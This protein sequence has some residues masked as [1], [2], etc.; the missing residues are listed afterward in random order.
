MKKIFAILALF[1]A[2]SI[3][4]N[5][6]ENK[7]SSDVTVSANNDFE[8]LNSFLTVD[9]ALKP[10]LVQI[11]K[12]KHEALSKPN[13]DANEKKNQTGIAARSLSQVLSQDQMQKLYANNELFDRL[14]R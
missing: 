6:Q 10:K 14:T 8:A 7:P 2:F 9:P 1:L 3:S 11:F 4:A 5:A 13:I 12:T